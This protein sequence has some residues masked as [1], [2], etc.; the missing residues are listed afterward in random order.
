MAAAAE[1]VVV[2]WYQIARIELFQVEEA[3]FFKSIL[4]Q[5]SPG[6]K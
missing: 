4:E 5:V 2:S 6:R 3:V 1:S